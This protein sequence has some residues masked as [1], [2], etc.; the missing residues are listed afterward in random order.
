MSGLGTMCI[1]DF[2]KSSCSGR[3]LIQ[4]CTRTAGTNT[5]FS[6]NY[7]GGQKAL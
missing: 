2:L 3:D 6:D 1:S 5:N 7:S 4:M